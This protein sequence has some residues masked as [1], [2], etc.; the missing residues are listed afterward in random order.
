M[1]RMESVISKRKLDLRIDMRVVLI[2]VIS[3]LLGRVNI[4][5]RLYPFGIAFMGAHI[6]LRNP[7]KKIII[8]TLLG[9]FSSLGLESLSYILSGALIYVF[10]KKY[11]GSS[12]YPLITSSIIAGGLFTIIRLIGFNAFEMVSIYDM[13]LILFEGIL[14]F[15]MTYV[16]SF[17][18]PVESI[19]E[20]Q[21]SNEKLICTFGTLAL[22]RSGI[23]SLSIW[24]F[25]LKILPVYFL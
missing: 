22:C 13:I 17:G 20:S 7:N 4:L 2:V 12:K 24:K 8:S 6:I 11:K 10:F 15:T 3:F 5:N 21:I 25:P 9:T 19:Y 18:F 1:A 14:V 16:F 23:G